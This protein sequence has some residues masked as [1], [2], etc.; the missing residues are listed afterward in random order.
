MCRVQEEI[1]CLNVEICHPVTCIRDE[2]NYLQTCEV[3]LKFHSPALAHQLAIHCNTRGRFN[4]RH[5]KR[6]HDISTLSGFSG[7][8]VPGLSVCMGLGESASAPD[9][10]PVYVLTDNMHRDKLSLPVCADTHEDLDEEEQEEEIAEEVSRNLQD[11]LLVT[12][13][14]DGSSL[15]IAWLTHLNVAIDCMS[16]NDDCYENAPSKCLC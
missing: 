15:M 10:I 11:V 7:T 13:N 1:S 16:Y 9:V 5:L 3:Q 14:F 4:A 6:L 8:L 2:D 12:D